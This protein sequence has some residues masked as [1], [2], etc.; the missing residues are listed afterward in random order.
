MCG[1]SEMRPTILSRSMM[2]NW[3]R[4]PKGKITFILSFQDFITFLG[5]VGMIA[6]LE[7]CCL[8][9]VQSVK[10]CVVILWI[11]EYR[12]FLTAYDCNVQFSSVTA[13]YSWGNIGSRLKPRSH[14]NAFEFI[15]FQ[16][17]SIQFRKQHSAVKINKWNMFSF[18]LLLWKAIK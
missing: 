6:F 13:G 11:V 2:R 17:N 4:R 9:F 12:D 14:E 3:S 18:I 8:I 7:E 16:F 1:S 15:S 10:S 5:L